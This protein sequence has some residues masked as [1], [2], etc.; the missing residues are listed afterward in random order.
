M[1][2]EVE[3]NV[4]EMKTKNFIVRYTATY[5]Q[6][7]WEAIT[8]YME[9]D[10]IEKLAEQYENGEIIIFDCL[11]EVIHKETNEILG[12]DRIGNCIHENFKD[13]I[14]Y[15][16]TGYTAS[17]NKL[18]KNPDDFHSKETVKHFEKYGN[19]KFGSY[20]KDLVSGAI[21]Q[22][23]QSEEYHLLKMQKRIKEF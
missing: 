15:V 21:K 7:F 20:F 16:G 5:S 9:E 13:F 18:Q 12:E 6:D 22:A 23:K 8:D 4:Y 10:I 19:N 3:G 17:L 2:K 1:F 14:D 11:L